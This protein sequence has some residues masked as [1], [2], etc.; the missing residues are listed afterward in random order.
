MAPYTFEL[1]APYNKKVGLRLKNANARMFG[2][3]IPM[4]LNQE[5]GYWRA[6]L[7][8]PDGKICLFIF[9][10]FEFCFPKGIY[11]YQYKVVTKSWFEPEP[12]PAVPEYNNDETKTP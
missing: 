3:D 1:F 5:D 6:T 8:L 10:K 12:E 7:D 4:E 11:H 2:L 9:T